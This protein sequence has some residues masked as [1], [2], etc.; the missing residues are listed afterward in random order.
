MIQ[1]ILF[2]CLAGLVDAVVAA[3]GPGVLALAETEFGLWLALLAALGLA[4]LA[5]DRFRL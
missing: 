2:F 5:T 3:D 1:T 4:G